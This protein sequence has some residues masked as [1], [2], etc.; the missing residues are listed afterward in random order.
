MIGR[1]ESE[2][3]RKPRPL[4]ARFLTTSPNTSSKF[5][6]PLVSK[7]LRS[8][9]PEVDGWRIA[10]DELKTRDEGMAME[11]CR[12]SCKDVTLLTTALASSCNSFG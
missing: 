6:A 7:C 12:K 9:K 5:E 4:H 8:L 1:L 3:E 10:Y 11:Y 2:G